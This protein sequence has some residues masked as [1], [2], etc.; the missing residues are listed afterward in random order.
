MKTWVIIFEAIVIYI[1]FPLLIVTG[2]LSSQFIMPL[3]WISFIYAAIILY[4][5][6][7][8]LSLFHIELKELLIVLKHFFI[9]APIISFFVWYY[10]PDIL[11]SFVIN[12]RLLWII[13]MFLYPILS[14]FTQEVIFRAFFTYR[15]ENIIKNRYI[16]ILINAIIFS[17][18]HCVFE[19]MIAIIFTFFGSLLFMNTYLRSRSLLLCSIEHSLYG[20]LIFTLGIGQYFYHAS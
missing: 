11:F 13:V 7:P 3:L 8:N 2:L 14:A 17:Y 19:N 6:K 20:N 18:I 5:S 16:L 12:N 1:T 4:R 15:F 9:I 10:Y